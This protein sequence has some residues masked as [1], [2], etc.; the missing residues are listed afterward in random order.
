MP[1]FKSLKRKP[2]SKKRKARWGKPAAFWLSAIG[3]P[4]SPALHLKTGSLSMSCWWAVGE[5]GDLCLCRWQSARVCTRGHLSTGCFG[6]LNERVIVRLQGNTRKKT[7]RTLRESGDR[8]G[9]VLENLEPFWLNFPARPSAGTFF[10]DSRYTGQDME[11]LSCGSCSQLVTHRPVPKTGWPNQ[12]R[13][14]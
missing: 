2:K 7:S 11:V 8:L 4:Q 13:W 3:F 5:L 9:G 6:M 1:V 14:G 12:G 10:G